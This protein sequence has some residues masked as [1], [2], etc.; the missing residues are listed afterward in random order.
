MAWLR[1]DYL[2][3]LNVAESRVVEGRVARIAATRV[4]ES[5]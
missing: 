2:E 5:G 4:A 1:L 3:Y